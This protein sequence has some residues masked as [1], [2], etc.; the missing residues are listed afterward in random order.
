M[1]CEKSAFHFVVN[2]KMCKK[3]M[4]Q[5]FLDSSEDIFQ[6]DSKIVSCSENT[7]KTVV[8]SN[9]IETPFK[10]DTILYN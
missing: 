8:L 6:S 1:C 9:K 2:E 10:I 4:I 5:L 7:R 3:R